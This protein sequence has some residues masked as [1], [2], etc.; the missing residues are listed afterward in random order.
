M[1]V[2]GRGWKIA[3][4]V[5]KG[6]DAVWYFEPLAGHDA[7]FEQ[8]FEPVQFAVD[9]TILPIRRGARAGRHTFSVKL[10]PEHLGREVKLAFTYR[11]LEPGS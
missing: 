6:K 5:D 10:W 4:L 7:A 1:G 9:G 2:G 3:H 8:A 11:V